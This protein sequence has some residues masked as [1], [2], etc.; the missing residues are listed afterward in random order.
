MI[1]TRSITLVC[2]LAVA[3]TTALAEPP[4]LVPVS[5]YLTDAADTALDGVYELGFGLFDAAVGGEVF[6]TSTQA[7]TVERGNFTIYLGEQGGAL[8]LRDFHTRAEVWLEVTIVKACGDDRMCQQEDTA[9]SQVLPRLRLATAAYAASASFCGD[10]QTLEGKSASAFAAADHTHAF[11]DLS[12]PPP[13]PPAHKHGCKWQNNTVSFSDGNGIAGYRSNCP[14]GQHVV[15]GGC[16]VQGNAVIQDSWPDQ[17]QGS[18]FC[19]S[20]IP[21]TNEI[22]AVMNVYALCC[23][24]ND[25]I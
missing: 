15:A 4:P 25:G 11:A 21:E 19:R 14:A 22:G 18:W 1:N 24:N 9:I 20:R 7:V 8:G 16:N 17:G 10:A 23:P 12:G 3:R 6:F 5:G 13:A 2:L